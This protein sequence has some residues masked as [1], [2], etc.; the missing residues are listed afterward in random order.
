MINR[1]T[2]RVVS[3][4]VAMSMILSLIGSVVEASV[5]SWLSPLPGQKLNT[6][7]V[8]VAIGYNTQSDVTVT[9]LELWVDGKLYSRKTLIRPITHGVCSFWWDTYK[10]SEG[11]HNLA[12]KIYSNEELLSKISSTG[13]VGS[14]TYDRRAPVVSFANV[15][16]GDLLTGI[17]TI[18]LNAKDDSG[19][20]PLVSLLVDKALKLIKNQ[21]PYSYDLDTTSY[22][23]G[24]HEMETYAYD[25][26]G[27]KSDP[28]VVKV[29]FKNKQELPVV[30]AVVVNSHPN[31]ASLDEAPA[32]SVPTIT[33]TPAR[34]SARRGASRS[35]ASG[36]GLSKASMPAYSVASAAKTSVKLGRPMTPVQVS[37][38]AVIAKPSVSAVSSQAEPRSYQAKPQHSFQP[39]HSIEPAVPVD[40]AV[41]SVLPV[42]VT[43]LPAGIVGDESGTA[44]SK[45][46]AVEPG[47]MGEP[48][49]SEAVQ[50]AMAVPSAEL[51]SDAL[52][53]IPSASLRGGEEVL[54]DPVL[55]DARTV[56]VPSP[57]SSLRASVTRASSSRH[58]MSAY[59]PKAA[60]ASA[61]KSKPAR[62]AS[63][64]YVD[65]ATSK[66]ASTKRIACPLQ[67]K[68]E[69][70][71]KLEKRTVPATGKVK[72]RDL[73]ND[74]H[75]VLFWDSEDHIITA[76][77]G[78]MKLELEIGSKI[79]RVNGIEMRL[80][81]APRITADGRT[82]ID[83]SIYHQAC[84]MLA[85]GTANRSANAR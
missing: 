15:K 16:S 81:T 2:L 79:A 30:A 24:S 48:V 69:V 60:T 12:V 73:F 50:M 57:S 80:T 39:R 36:N 10:Y 19:D 64:A 9:M 74:L 20:Q 13:N 25:S 55:A 38:P 59:A 23:N 43:Q 61:S 70:R 66:R 49:A 34:P 35:E 67:I 26:E 8:E 11:P 4:A 3:L 44:S 52:S 47:P 46:A 75:G 21:P 76:Y 45:H 54:A 37:V 28:A 83:I 41:S 85:S 32:E 58:R 68:K 18:K 5:G 63:A 56:A 14:Y 84:A 77:A 7:N 17:T 29:A 51:R 31:M 27:N 40:P 78:N 82:V 53:S 22:P 6:R 1:R 72:L 71:A 42:D 65:D 33:D 62:M